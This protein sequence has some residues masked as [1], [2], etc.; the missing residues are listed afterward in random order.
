MLY[1]IVKRRG[2]KIFSSKTEQVISK[3]VVIWNRI[4]ITFLT[5]LKKDTVVAEKCNIYF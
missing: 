2:Q 4:T 5:L 1:S 3:M